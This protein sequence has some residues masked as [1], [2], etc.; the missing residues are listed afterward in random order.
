MAKMF[1]KTFEEA[2]S[3]NIGTSEPHLIEYLYS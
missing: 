3:V 1:S 2:L